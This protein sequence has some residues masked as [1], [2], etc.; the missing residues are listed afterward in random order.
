MNDQTLQTLEQTAE[1]LAPIAGAALKASSPGAA[2]ALTLLPV[3]IQL[4]NSAGQLVQA[5]AM[6]QAQLAEL[7]ATIGQGIA[8]AHSQWA[9]MN[10]ADEASHPV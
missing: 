2:A 6:S 1:T 3:A 7:F 4:L 8:S 9:A 5:G 10:V